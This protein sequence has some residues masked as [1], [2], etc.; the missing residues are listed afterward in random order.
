MRAGFALGYSCGRPIIEA[1]LSS[2]PCRAKSSP[3]KLDSAGIKVSSSYSYMMLFYFHF[4]NDVIR[5]SYELLVLS[6]K[7]LAQNTRYAT[8]VCLLFTSSRLCCL[9]LNFKPATAS[10]TAC[11]VSALFFVTA[12][13][14]VLMCCTSTAVMI[15]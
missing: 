1:S 14:C 9:F 2:P 3:C 10:C 5:V 11:S 15:F 6:T 13:A 4:C 7:Y 12:V 8:A